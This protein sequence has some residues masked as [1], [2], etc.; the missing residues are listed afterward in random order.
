VVGGFQKIAVEQDAIDSLIKK[1]V[2]VLLKKKL[3]H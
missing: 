1:I 3:S 2:F